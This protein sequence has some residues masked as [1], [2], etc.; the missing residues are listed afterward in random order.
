MNFCRPILLL[1]LTVTCT[2]RTCPSAN[3]QTEHN[4]GNWNSLILKGKINPRWSMMFESHIR[5]S[6]YSMKYDYMEAKGGISYSLSKKLTSLFGSGF[7]NF[8]QQGGLFETPALLKE[9]RTWLELSLKQSCHRF[10]FDHRIRVEQ[11]FI[12]K[13]YK[14]RFRYRLAITVPVNKAKIEPG[15]IYFTVND[16]LWMPQYGPWIEKNRLFTGAGYRMNGNTNLQIGLIHDN[17]YKLNDYH[18]V[19]NY[20]QMMIT[21]DITRIIKKHS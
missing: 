4:L 1:L 6:T 14:N 11:R 2:L 9:F 17:D 16:E 5:S 20:I 13:N 8:Y 15:S 19:T 10:N 7:Y 12:P 21:Y 18:S 3:A